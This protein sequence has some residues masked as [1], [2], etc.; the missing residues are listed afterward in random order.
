PKGTHTIEGETALAYVRTRHSVGFGGD[1]SRIG[2]QQQFLSA[3]MRKLKSNDTL[4]SPSKMIKLA[5]AGTE[6]LTVD[7]QL[8]SINKLKDL[9]L[10]LG[11]LNTENLTF[12]TVPVIDNPSEQVKATVVLDGAQAPQV[13]DLIRNDVSMTEVKQ[14]KKKEKA[15]YGARREGA[16]TPAAG[17]V[18]RLGD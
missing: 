17:V 16:T 7:S 3:L 11:K 12:T 1:L 10:E 18:G 13:F 15:A 5:E 8:D 9:G 4:T 2:L 6:A 14:K